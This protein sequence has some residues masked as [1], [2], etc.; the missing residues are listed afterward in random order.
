LDCLRFGRLLALLLEQNAE[1]LGQGLREGRFKHRI[2]LD[3]ALNVPRHPAKWAAAGFVDAE[4]SY[5]TFFSNSTGL[6]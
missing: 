5:P 1:R 4:L 2:S 6:R 3:L